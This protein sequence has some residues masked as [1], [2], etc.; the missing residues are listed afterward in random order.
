MKRA[1]LGVLV[2]VLLLTAACLG[3]AVTRA[4]SVAIALSGSHLTGWGLTKASESIPGPTI[5]VNQNDVVTLSLTSTDG[6]PHQFLLDYNGNGIADPG[7]PVSAFFSSTTT[8]TFTASVAGSFPYICTVHPSAMFGT[9]TVGAANTPPVLSSLA[10]SPSPAV[11]GQPATFSATVSDADGDTVS[12]SVDWG[13]GSAPTAGTTGAGGGS[14]SAIHTYSLAG[15]FVLTLSA[16]DGKAGGQATQTLSVSVVTPPAMTLVLASSRTEMMSNETATIHAVLSSG[17]TLVT[18]ATLTPSSP[19][20]GKFSAVRNLGSGNYEFDWTAPVVTHQTFAPINV[21]AKASGFQDT[22]AR[23]VILVDPDETNLANPTQLFLLVRSPAT[24]LSVGQS[25]T[26]TVYVYTI[27]GYVVSGATVSVVRVGPGAVSAVT[28]RLNGVYTF[29]YTAPSS[30]SGPTGVLITIAVSK[31]G[32]ANASARLALT[33][34][35]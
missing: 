23:V 18:S 2:G 31:L 6:F 3:L 30:V 1:V 25:L 13:D 20:G 19:L 15:T 32:Y 26:V 5:T 29:V 17:S 10:I 24:S 34:V 4:A 33:V 7:E 9:W 8:L 22:S 12:Y 28:D 35:P 27:Q 21:A 16:S 11:A 14:I